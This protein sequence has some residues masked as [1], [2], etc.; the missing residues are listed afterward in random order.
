MA[1]RRPESPETIH[2]ILMRRVSRDYYGV[3]GIPIVKGRIPDRDTESREIVVNEAAARSLWA[4]ADPIG[5]TLENAI[6]RTEFQSYMVVGIAKHV[7][8]RSMSEIEP[9][10]YR[11]LD[12][13]PANW[14]ATFLVRGGPPGIGQRGGE[15]RTGGHGDGAADGGLRA[16]LADDQAGQSRGVGDRRSRSGARNGGRLRCVR[17]SRRVAPTRDLHPDGARLV[18]GTDCQARASNREQRLRTRPTQTNAL[19]V[20]TK[21]EKPLVDYRERRHRVMV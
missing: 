7:P 12:W 18:P 9:V 20:T 15:P 3:L 11:T 21:P 14:T 6:S 8:V 4:G 10:I 1:A 13:M 19:T 5:R 16:R 2:S 17:A